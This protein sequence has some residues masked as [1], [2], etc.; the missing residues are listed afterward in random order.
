M[1]KAMHRI[2]CAQKIR[3]AN[4]I[5]HTLV[6]SNA[7]FPAQKETEAPINDEYKQKQV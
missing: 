7:I 6:T 2:S 3:I 5:A 4:G 1:L